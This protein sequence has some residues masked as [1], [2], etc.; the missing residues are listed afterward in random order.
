MKKIT[1]YV[2]LLTVSSVSTTAIADNPASQSWVMDQI[3]KA[4]SI[5]PSGPP[6]P[7]GPVGPVGPK[8]DTGA[9][10]PQGLPGPRGLK[11]DKGEQGI[12]GPKGDTGAAGPKGD[13][14]ATGPQGLKGDTGAQGIQ[15][16]KGEQG[17][18][19][20]KGDTGAAGPKGD[21][22]ATGPQG[23]KGDTGAQ[24]IQ[25]AQGLK[26][27][28]GP[29]GP[30]GDTGAG[31]P[32]YSIGDK[33]PAYTSATPTSDNK[34]GIVFFVY[35]IP[36]PTG[37]PG[38]GLHGLI[39]AKAD[40]NSSQWGV[41][42]EETQATEDGYAGAGTINTSKIVK[43]FAGSTYT[44]NLC[45]SYSAIAGGT[46]YKDWYLPAVW[47]LN[48]MY[49]NKGIIG[50]FDTNLNYWSSNEDPTPSP[51]CPLCSAFAEHFSNGTISSP[52]KQS[53]LHA[54][55]IRAF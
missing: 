26:G 16:E 34:I 2:A 32:L 28:T 15:G 24:G 41:E 46:T 9:T 50:G 40:L 44:A 53:Q 33:Y 7:Q 17:I 35:D 18:Q 48:E 52:S 47:E 54:R 27:D 11:G 10:G 22:G 29:I 14:G 12:Q 23:L 45:D 19:G 36:D 21:T 1:F 6:G 43:K 31:M 25:G 42:R 49:K 3:H 5:I 4:I 13:T 30:K 20:P 55:C 8:G 39:A 37:H 51:T 38:A